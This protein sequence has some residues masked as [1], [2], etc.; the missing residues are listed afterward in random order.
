MPPSLRDSTPHVPARFSSVS[1]YSRCLVPGNEVESNPSRGTAARFALDTMKCQAL[2]CRLM[3]NAV[4]Q[5]CVACIFEKCVWPSIFTA[6][7]AMSDSRRCTTTALTVVWRFPLAFCMRLPRRLALRLRRRQAL[8]SV[9]Y[10]RM[11]L[12][13]PPCPRSMA[14]RNTQLLQ[15]ITVHYA[16]GWLRPCP[17]SAALVSSTTDRS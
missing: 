11:C 5:L 3:G 8:L 7:I 9:R 6:P 16:P 12:R 4:P 1:L 15:P 10:R 14:W 13:H 2:R 17:S